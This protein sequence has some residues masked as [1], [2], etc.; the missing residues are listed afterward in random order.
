MNSLEYYMSLPYKVEIV[1]DMEEGGYTAYCP[2]LPGCI[3]C[4]ETMDGIIENIIDAKKEG[5]SMNQYCVYLLSA[6]NVYR[7]NN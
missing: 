7:S 2:D 4:S 3:T 6:N 5:V 1:P